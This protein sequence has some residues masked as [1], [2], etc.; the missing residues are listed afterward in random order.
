M[1]RVSQHTSLIQVNLKQ[2]NE[3][4]LGDWESNPGLGIMISYFIML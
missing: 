3:K 1:K 2:M 4:S